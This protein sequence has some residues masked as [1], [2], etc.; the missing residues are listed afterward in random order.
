MLCLALVF[1]KKDVKL[2]AKKYVEV[3]LKE[4]DAIAENR[5]LRREEKDLVWLG[6]VKEQFNEGLIKYTPMHPINIA[7]Q[8][9][10]NDQL[11]TEEVYDAILKRLNPMNLVPLIENENKVYTPIDS[12]DSPEWMYYTEY[13]HSEQSVP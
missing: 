3:Y 12:N 6:V 7:Y 4:L 5:A 9:Y 11:G 1:L 13:L 10:L 2:L 8:L